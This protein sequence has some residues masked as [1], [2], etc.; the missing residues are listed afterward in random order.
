MSKLFQVAKKS[1]SMK[2]SERR[3]KANIVVKKE[4]N[5]L[6]REHISHEIHSHEHIFWGFADYKKWRSA[7]RKF[8]SFLYFL[9]SSQHLRTKKADWK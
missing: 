2:G 3:E 9:A 6:V 4:E 7:E 5:L 8:L 1:K